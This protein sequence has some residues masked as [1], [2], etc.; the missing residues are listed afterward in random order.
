MSE[1]NA[2]VIEGNVRE[3]PAKRLYRS[4]TNRSVAGVCGGV[5]EYF[6][7]DVGLVRVIWLLSVLLTAGA[8][9]VLYVLLVFV[10]PEESAE[11]AATKQVRTGDLW[12]R[13]KA[14]PT[15]LWG[16]L[17]LLAG[18]LLL[19]NNFDLLPWRLEQVWNAFWA[20]FWPLLL[21]G[22]GVGLLLSFT[23]HAPDWRQWRQARANLPLRRSRDDR[24][25]AGVCGGLGHYL[26]VDPVLV[27]VAWVLLSIVTVGTVGV[28]LYVV[29]ALVLPS[30]P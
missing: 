30:E 1:Q 17:L 13:I 7:L 5:G 28:L 10:V 26:H 11:H 14:N 4:S 6:G 16:G 20:L 21:I 27:R 23:G 25:I 15:L 9:L 22:V 19:L 29:A 12:Q 24:V 3:V 8:T 2:T 18:L